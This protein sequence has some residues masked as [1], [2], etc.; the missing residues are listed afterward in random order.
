MQ[1]SSIPRVSINFLGFPQSSPTAG[2]DVEIRQSAIIAPARRLIVELPN[3][4]NN[5]STTKS[6]RGENSSPHLLIDFLKQ[7]RET[8]LASDKG[9]TDLTTSSIIVYNQE[10]IQLHLDTPAGVCI[11]DGDSLIIAYQGRQVKKLHTSKQEVPIHV[12]SSL[13]ATS[14]QPPP[15][16]QHSFLIDAAP[17]LVAQPPRSITSSPKLGK[18]KPMG[19]DH[20][21]SGKPRISAS[22]L[23]PQE[24]LV[25]GDPV[26]TVSVNPVAPANEKSN[27]VK[28]TPK[29]EEPSLPSLPPTT[30]ATTT[31]PTTAQQ[32]ITSSNEIVSTA[33]SNPAAELTEQA[34]TMKVQGLVSRRT[35][36][37]S[38]SRTSRKEATTTTGAMTTTTSTTIEVVVGE[39]SLPQETA[40][41]VATTITTT[42]SASITTNNS[43]SSRSPEDPPWVLF[44]DHYQEKHRQRVTAPHVLMHPENEPLESNIVFPGAPKSVKIQHRVEDQ[45]Q[46]TPT[47]ALE[48]LMEQ[49]QQI[50]ADRT[51]TKAGP[52][53]RK[54][55]TE[56]TV[57]KSHH[58]TVNSKQFSKGKNL[59][60]RGG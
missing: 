56:D 17:P 10:F 41:V 59:G 12:K 1:L 20:D 49:Q 24:P 14:A 29:I 26:E 37:S 55:S 34:P 15:P 36:T 42:S 33:N 11:R 18:L 22:M 30:A 35:K 32:T 31:K 27:S 40:G 45:E 28:R 6:A 38:H 19:S 58:L 48:E 3:F 16:P 44:G 57:D 52:S 4:N 2:E 25:V 9:V 43:T 39:A 21:I 54:R 60:L 8:V 53:G 47:L 46:P 7:L 13:Q 5:Q 51:S 23:T 50:K